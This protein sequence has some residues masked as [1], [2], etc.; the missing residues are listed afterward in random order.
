MACHIIGAELLDKYPADEFADVLESCL[1]NRLAPPFTLGRTKGVFRAAVAAALRSELNE[2]TVRPYWTA[3]FQFT[4]TATAVPHPA[5]M[6]AVP[7]VQAM[8]VRLLAGC[9]GSGAGKLA[10]AEVAE[11]AVLEQQAAPPPHPGW[12]AFYAAWVASSGTALR[13]FVQSDVERDAAGGWRPVVELDRD[14]TADFASCSAVGGS[15]V[16][17]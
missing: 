10:L 3:P 16:L 7:P 5:L 9:R 17:W 4:A 1:P 2:M 15:S 8:V 12:V 6:T 13:D 11:R 14:G